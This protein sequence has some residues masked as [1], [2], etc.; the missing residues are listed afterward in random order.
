[1]AVLRP[2]KS[3]KSGAGGAREARE[4]VFA[5]RGEAH[6]SASANHQAG[7][8]YQRAAEN[9]A[10]A[11]DHVDRALAQWSREMPDVKVSGAE[12]LN[13]ARRLVLE[14]RAPIEEAL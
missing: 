12:V 9:V 8:K 5:K 10:E 1:M 4:S 3:R 6:G 13:R 14:T 2:M 11:A 7:E